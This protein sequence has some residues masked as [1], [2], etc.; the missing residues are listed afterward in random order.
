MQRAL[1]KQF[2]LILENQTG[3][4]TARDL[5]ARELF[6]IYPYRIKIQQFS[7]NAV[8]KDEWTMLNISEF[9]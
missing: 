1:G 8:K 4:S 2:L 3:V 6:L 7:L 9:S 5:M